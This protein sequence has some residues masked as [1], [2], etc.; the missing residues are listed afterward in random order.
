MPGS[1]QVYGIH[2]T[3][4]RMKKNTIPNLT[5]LLH[6]RI[7]LKMNNKHIFEGTLIGYDAFMNLV[8]TDVTRPGDINSTVVLRGE[9]IENVVSIESIDK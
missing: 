9:C 2:I 6:K 7:A 1:P 4:D 8:L 5:K 3:L